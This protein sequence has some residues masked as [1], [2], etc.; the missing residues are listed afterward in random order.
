MTKTET[1]VRGLLAS[2][3]TEVKTASKRY[4]CFKRDDLAEGVFMWVGS[5]GALRRGRRTT[6]AMSLTNTVRY[7]EL[8][9]AGRRAA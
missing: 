2:N 4:R 6:D 9:D 8:L 7:R 3:Y 1:L 5:S